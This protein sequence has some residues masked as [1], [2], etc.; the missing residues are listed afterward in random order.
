MVC[1]HD[2]RPTHL[3]QIWR[4]KFFSC[5][6]TSLEWPSTWSTTAWILQLDIFV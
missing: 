1:I 2:N 4:Q 3:R 6:S 5:R